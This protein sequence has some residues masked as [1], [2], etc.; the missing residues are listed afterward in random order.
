M[1]INMLANFQVMSKEYFEIFTSHIYNHII[2]H[3][4]NVIN[5]CVK[6]GNFS[7]LNIIIESVVEPLNLPK[8]L[9]HYILNGQNIESNDLGNLFDTFGVKCVKIRL[10][11]YIKSIVKTDFTLDDVKA[12]LDMKDLVMKLYI[13]KIEKLENTVMSQTMFINKQSENMTM[14]QKQLGRKTLELAALNQNNYFSPLSSPSTPPGLSSPPGFETKPKVFSVL[15]NKT[16]DEIAK[17]LGLPKSYK[18][19]SPILFNLKNTIWG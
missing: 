11:E 1:N 16:E 7:N 9:T 8:N 17:F 12:I 13:N 2:A 5:V 14:L 18:Y 6:I 3:Y 19:D 15:Q 4:S 10:E